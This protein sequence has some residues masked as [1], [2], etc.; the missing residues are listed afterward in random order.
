MRGC[1][2][3]KAWPTFNR[4]IF[5]IIV[6]WRKGGKSFHDYPGKGQ[7]A[8]AW[9]F[10]GQRSAADIAG[11]LLDLKWQ[12]P[13]GDTSRW[14]IHDRWIGVDSACHPILSANWVPLRL[15]PEPM[16]I[17]DHIAR[18]RMGVWS[19]LF[20]ARQERAWRSCCRRSSPDSLVRWPI[21]AVG[22]F[23]VTRL[24]DVA[25]RSSWFPS[26]AVPGDLLTL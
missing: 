3:W 14:W 9:P 17:S 8:P 10:N 16:I 1:E 15:A 25:P 13:V 20:W 18:S 21:S 26:M 19:P 4:D 7:R 11:S 2:A 22:T 5:L 24:A 12:R 23:W 6:K